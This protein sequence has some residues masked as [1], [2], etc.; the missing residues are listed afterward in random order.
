MK[1][2]SA[3]RL[4]LGSVAF[5]SQ[6]A[7]G[8]VVAAPEPQSLLMTSKEVWEYANDVAENIR[9]T[10]ES[11]LS[12]PSDEQTFENTLRPWNRLS[13]QFSRNLRMLH[14]LEQSNSPLGIAASE[15]SDNLRRFL[16]EFSQNSYF[17]QALMSCSQKTAQNAELNPFQ[18]YIANRFI[19]NRSNEPYYLYG[20]LE[21]NNTSLSEFTVLNLKSAF[22]AENGFTDFCLKILSTNADMVCIQEVFA[23]GYAY[24]LYEALRDSYT[25]FMYIPPAAMSDDLE[26]YHNVGLLIASK[27]R[28]NISQEDNNAN[29]EFLDFVV[30]SESGSL[31]YSD[32]VYL[33]NDSIKEGMA[34]NLLQFLEKI[35]VFPNEIISA[36]YAISTITVLDDHSGLLTTIKKNK[37]CL[38]NSQSMLEDAPS[39]VLRADHVLKNIRKRYGEE[40]CIV[41]CSGHADVSAGVDIE[42]NAS[43]EVSVGTS[44]ESERGTTY[45]AEI[46]GSVE[47]DREGNISGKAE[48][49]TGVRW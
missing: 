12:V 48:V 45:S 29:K 28:L 15:A 39:M 22:L 49:T 42:G 13:A 24:D 4:V 10:A 1:S 35:R 25:H 41:L 37:S 2:E 17:Y 40:S 46:S 6:L 14:T 20:P 33:R 11:I 23:D 3:L 38:A 26:D 43:C 31:R 7:S 34:L 9:K 47:R 18:R 16:L 8:I 5:I 44:Y 27:Y 36:E 30:N 19:K 21:E 32:I